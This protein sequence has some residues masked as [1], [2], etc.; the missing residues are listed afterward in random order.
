M[1]NDEQLKHNLLKLDMNPFDKA[2]LWLA[3]KNAKPTSAVTTRLKKSEK[4]LKN[5]LTK[6][7]MHYIT[8]KGFAS[9]DSSPS[10]YLVSHKKENIEKLNTIFT[11]NS[12]KSHI[13]KGKLYGFPTKTL[14]FF[15]KRW[16]DIEKHKG[17]TGLEL[18]KKYGKNYSFVPYIVRA[19]HEKEDAEVSLKW[20]GI[21]KNDLPELY[22]KL[23]ENSNDL[24]KD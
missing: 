24:T 10:V 9:D 22:S 18:F 5:W 19:N 23:I 16:N 7:Q 17:T 4:Q 6:S 20:G 11:D 12:K 3:Y 2:L 13:E 1:N 15:A 21:I 14:E 8:N